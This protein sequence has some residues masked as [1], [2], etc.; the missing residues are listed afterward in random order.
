[1]S[2]IDMTADWKSWDPTY[3]PMEIL[4][5][6]PGWE[7]GQR[8]LANSETSSGVDLNQLR[9]PDVFE[10]TD[11]QVYLVYTGNGEGGLGIAKLY[12]T[13]STNIVL[14]A[15]ADSHV[16]ASSS[17]NFG[18]L[19]N[20]TASS[21]T[22]SMD[23]RTIYMRFDLTEVSKIE[24]ATVRLYAN[25][26]ETGTSVLDTGGPITI[27]KTSN[28]WEETTVTN[29]NAPELESVITTA[30]LTDAN[31][32]YDWNISE[33]AKANEGS[34]LTVAFDVAPTNDLSFKFDSVNKLDG[35][36]EQLLIKTNSSLSSEDIEPSSSKIII[37]TYPNP[38]TENFT[39]EVPQLKGQ[40]TLTVKLFD[41]L[42][43]TIASKETTN[44][45]SIVEFKNTSLKEGVYILK[46]SYTNGVNLIQKMIK[47]N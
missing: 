29:S 6:N 15:I 42:G 40:K 46:V 9:D 1:M 17:N 32:Y 45:S 31:T 12:E 26:S 39:V 10:D 33:Y 13:P 43:K 20:L 36:P 8:T 27:Y 38:F 22:N 37:K 30:Y 19:N 25:D 28:N 2:S 14:T 5:P 35:N 34:Q 41:V 3:P 11:G 47:T 4:A 24:H 23:K 44:H 16:R 21:G 18:S 7:G